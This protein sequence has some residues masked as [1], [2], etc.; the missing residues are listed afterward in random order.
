M[1]RSLQLLEQFYRGEFH[2]LSEEIEED[3]AKAQLDNEQGLTRLTDSELKDADIHSDKIAIRQANELPPL[4]L[5]LSEKRPT[6]LHWL[7]V[8]YGLTAKLHKFWKR[9]KF[10]PIYLRQTTN[11]LTGEHTCV[12]LKELPSDALALKTSSFWLD[13]FAKDFQRRFMTLLSFSFKEF[14]PVLAMS[15]IES[16]R[17]GRTSESLEADRKDKL[18]AAELYR[19]LSPFDLKRLD[20]YSHN[21]VDYHVIIDLVPVVADLVLRDRMHG[22]VDLSGVQL[23]LLMGIGLQRKSVD[24]IA[25]DLNL[26]GSQVLALFIKIIRKVSAHF[27]SIETKAASGSGSIN[28]QDMK[29]AGGIALTNSQDNGGDDSLG[30]LSNKKRSAKDEEAWEPLSESLDADFDEASKAVAA[31]LK[32]KQRELIDSMDLD[33][34]SIGGNDEDWKSAES[35][36]EKAT[37]SKTVSVLNP[38]STKKRKKG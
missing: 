10:V 1:L 22:V 8:S 33:Q 15:I 5:R 2:S 27:S 24:D 21:M 35:Q 37:G 20:S 16:I 31:D 3:G 4:F 12:M 32:K 26:P 11:D 17:C 23:C 7:G 29:S 19:L 38:D 30:I 18:S 36:L 14:T 9:S 13:A 25:A 6:R 28:D 34:Y